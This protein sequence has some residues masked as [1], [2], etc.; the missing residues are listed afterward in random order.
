M[1]GCLD[2]VEEEKKTGIHVYKKKEYRLFLFLCA[3]YWPK[4]G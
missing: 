2:R 4:T 3:D 1:R